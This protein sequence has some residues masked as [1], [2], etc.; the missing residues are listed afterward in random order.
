M[1][2]KRLLLV[3]SVSIGTA[4]CAIHPLPEDVSGYNTYQIVS[5][6]RCEAREAVRK[7]A[8]EYIRRR[9]PHIAAGLENRTIRYKNFDRNLVDLRTQVGLERYD[10][11][12]I[13]YDFTFDITEKNNVTANADLT[14]FLSRGPLNIGL[15]AGNERERQNS[16]NFR[17]VDTFEGLINLDS[18]D[19]CRY[20][21][22]RANFTY[23]ITGAIG[24]SET[25]ATFVSLNDAGNLAGQ[26]GSNIPALSDTIE[27]TTKISGGVN[28]IITLSPL[29]RQL[30]LVKAAF[31]ANVSREDI[32]KV[33]VAVTLPPD[34]T[35]Q[36]VAIVS[37]RRV[38][39]VRTRQGKLS[40][41]NRAV[42]ELDYQRR[43]GIDDRFDRFRRRIEGIIE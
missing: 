20:Y 22:E 11:G 23:P 35:E 26:E 5:K 36:E 42:Q 21:E 3:C 4:G 17:I 14:R 43:R 19:Y 15:S 31:D 18:D 27:F 34:P 13:A 12:A 24:L 38:G 40:T 37:G 28:P 33:V 41:E 6:I 1:L 10:R 16:R 30:Q 7:I 8:V 29:G 25:I 9:N 39:R 2:L 32:H